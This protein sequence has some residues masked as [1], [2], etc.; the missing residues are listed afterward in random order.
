MTGCGCFRCRDGNLG[1]VSIPASCSVAGV[2]CPSVGPSAL[3]TQFP[4]SPPWPSPGEVGTGPCCS[5]GG[6]SSFSVEHFPPGST[7]LEPACL[8]VRGTSSRVQF[9]S[10][11]FGDGA[12]SSAI[13]TC[14]RVQGRWLGCTLIYHRQ[15]H[16]RGL[17]RERLAVCDT[18]VCFQHC[19]EVRSSL[20]IAWALRSL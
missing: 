19:F 12:R 16:P 5:P 6:T 11:I 18:P 10:L 4:F 15:S 1:Q 3:G 7:R 17:M 8:A 2:Q 20:T 14:R 13:C 9:S